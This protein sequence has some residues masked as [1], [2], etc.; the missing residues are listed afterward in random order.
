MRI[1][2]TNDDG[3]DAPGLVALAR[4]LQGKAKVTVCA[5]L[6]QRSAD[7]S[8]ITLYQPLIVKR[9][10]ERGVLWASIDG[11]PADCVKLALSELLDTP[12]NL[13]LS[14]INHGLNT[15][16]NILYSGTI[17]AALEACQFGIQAMAISREATP[18]TGGK[19]SQEA[20]YRPAAAAAWRLVQW[21]WKSHRNPKVVYNIN[22]PALPRAKLRGVMMTRQE[23][24]PYQD[25][26]ERRVD[27]RGR[28]YY[29]L[30]GSPEAR[31]KNFFAQNGQQKDPTD[32]YAVA[33]GYLSVSP[34]RRDLTSFDAL[35]TLRRS[36]P[37]PRGV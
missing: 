7:S 25:A 18:L 34:L 15:G 10:T 3:I 11:T 20:A 17:A 28:T 33:N 32:A 23:G 26:F 35:Q 9:R 31:F 1:L 8:S 22:V 27:P 19:R 37:P 4:V 14:G 21:L 2:L 24:T 36:P 12:P 30:C 13:V 6:R 29:W 16:S 5:P